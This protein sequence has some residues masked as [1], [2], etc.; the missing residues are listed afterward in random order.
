MRYLLSLRGKKGDKYLKLVRFD[1]IGEEQFD[2]YIEEWENEPQKIVPSSCKR[3]NKTFNEMMTKWKNDETDDVVLRG[4]VPS[5]LFF[6]V[7]ESQRI[8]GAIHLRHHLN[9]R[10]L[11]HG[12]HIGYGIRPSERRKGYATIML[13]LLVD[14]LKELDYDKVMLTCDEDNI[15]S[16]KTIENCNG[17]L[18][19]NAL[20]DGVLTR[21]YWIHL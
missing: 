4:F 15:G 3:K 12:G 1:E 18:S 19:E 8:L 13:K 14:K 20:F 2:E 5:T 21:T 10:L 11:Q 16:I 7:D 6:S 17:V 9:E